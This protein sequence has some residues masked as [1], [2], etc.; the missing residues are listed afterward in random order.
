MN[1]RF[2][3]RFP[4]GLDFLY[5]VLYPFLPVMDIF[6]VNLKFCHICFHTL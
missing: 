6:S 5:N 2:I 4:I 3:V 1:Y